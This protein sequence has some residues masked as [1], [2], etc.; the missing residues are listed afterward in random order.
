MSDWVASYDA[1]VKADTAT[2]SNPKSGATMAFRGGGHSVSIHGYKGPTSSLNGAP[3]P[4]HTFGA[5]MAGYAGAQNGGY[6]Y[7]KNVFPPASYGRG[8]AI[9]AASYRGRGQTNVQQHYPPGHNPYRYVAPKPV[10]VDDD[11]MEKPMKPE[12]VALLNKFLHKKVDLMQNSGID[13]SLDRN[14]PRSPLHSIRSFR[15]LRLRS[16]LLEAL[17]VLGFTQPSKI[18]EFALPLLIMEPPTNIIAQSQS[19]TGKTATFVLTMLSRVDPSKKLPQCLCLAPTY[20]LAIQIG[21]VVA[22]I[23]QFMP[24]V[25]VHFAVRG[26]KPSAPIT[27]QIIIGTPGKLVDYIAKYHCLDPSHICCL[28]LDEADVMINQ[29]G[30][31]EQSTQIYKTIE[32]HSPGVQTML[33]SA[34]YGE[35]VVKFAMQLIKNA[36]TVTLKREDQALPNIK[37]YFVECQGRDAKYQAVVELYSGLTIASCVIFTH[38][39]R[40]AS[41][42]AERMVEKGHSVGVLHGEMSVEERAES[43]QRFKDGDFKVLITT[44]VCARGIDVTQVTIVI[45]YDPPLL[46]ENPSEPDYDTYLHRIGRTG[47][48]GKAGIAINF[49][50]SRE[51][52][53]IIKKIEAFFGK[54]IPRL[55]PSDLEQLEAVEND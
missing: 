16:E 10:P 8:Q 47:R 4:Q 24:E 50:D 23:A 20:E 33:F 7:T 31:T 17:N 42:L 6:G 19:G 36:V 18:Q 32:T 13:V 3:P 44:N 52:L 34:T 26:V 53:V 37:Q 28:V 15:D 55:D 12:E 49:V 45:N 9:S 48:F 46:Y 27:E 30:Y 41:W 25:K 38:T 43:I 2:D 29:A 54:P 35:D 40:S 11:V 14:D 39:R 51:A 5:S 21:E 22:K 1:Q